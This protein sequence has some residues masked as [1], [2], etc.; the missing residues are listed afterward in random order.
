MKTI[1]RRNFIKFALTSGVMI[2]SGGIFSGCNETSNDGGTLK[3]NL[4]VEFLRQIITSDSKSSHCVMW[5]VDSEMTAPLVE[6]RLKN[7]V[8]S[9]KVSAV[10][11]SFTDDGEKILQYTA[12]VENLSPDSDYEYR[13]I[14]GESCTDFFELQT[15]SEKNSRR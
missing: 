4:D 9:V 1:N 5:Q 7:S 11:S 10:D 6:V 8:E 15:P 2:G 3:N 13:I 12:Q 14:D